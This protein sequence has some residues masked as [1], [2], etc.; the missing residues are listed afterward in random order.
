L[1]VATSLSIV[2]MNKDQGLES[3][4]RERINANYGNVCNEPEFKI[5]CDNVQFDRNTAATDSGSN[6]RLHAS[7]PRVQA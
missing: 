4:S 6:A 2:S 3:L 7:N 1:E 5:T